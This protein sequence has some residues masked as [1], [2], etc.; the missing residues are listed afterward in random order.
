MQFC[1]HLGTGQQGELP[2]PPAQPTAGDGSSPGTEL[3]LPIPE[4]VCQSI[5]APGGVW[6]WGCCLSKQLLGLC[7]Q[8][9]VHLHGSLICHLLDLWQD[10]EIRVL[11]EVMP[12]FKGKGVTK[13]PFG[14]KLEVP[15]KTQ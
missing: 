5:P 8:Q 1:T 10:R 13:S 11:C 15:I 6:P 4:A 9:L 7:C 3:P 2:L 14:T 12:R